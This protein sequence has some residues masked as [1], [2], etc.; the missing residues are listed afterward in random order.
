MGRFFI[1]DIMEQT[2]KQPRHEISPLAPKIIT[3]KIP[4][5]M[6]GELIGP[7]GKNI[8]AIQADSGAT[9]EID[10]DGTV[11]I[12][13]ASAEAGETARYR[14]E[15]MLA[16]PEE[17]RTYS[18]CPVKRIESYGAF[19][20]F[21]PGKEGL[22]HVSEIAWE[23][24]REVSDV[25]KVGDK[26]N[27]LLKKIPQPGRYELSIREL[28]PKPAGYVEKSRSGNERYGNNSER[29]DRSGRRRLDDVPI[30]VVGNER[31]KIP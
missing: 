11:F 28:T 18:D 30:I 7:G 20:E 12:S 3:I 26:V 4:V 13:A 8:K 31:R 23:R 19:V 25:L 14:I 29:H 2:I 10:D 27:I 1:I 9:I 16:Q 17:G 24:T 21:L 22:L 6:I 15:T 5:E